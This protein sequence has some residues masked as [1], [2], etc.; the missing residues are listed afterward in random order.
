MKYFV[1]WEYEKED[2]AD[3][4]EKFK[5][6]PGAE[7][8]RLFPPGALGGQTKGFLLVEDDDFERVE[9]F[10]HHHSPMLKVKIFQS[11]NLQ[12]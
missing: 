11:L 12:K 8:T 6:R 5:V 2:E 10:L 4:I 1:F 3:L 7:I 9:K